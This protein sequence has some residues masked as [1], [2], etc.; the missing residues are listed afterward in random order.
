MVAPFGRLISSCLC[1]KAD[2]LPGRPTAA[3]PLA[4]PR[5]ISTLPPSDGC[6][7]TTTETLWSDAAAS[8][9]VG[10][11]KAKVHLKDCRFLK[12]VC[13]I[14]YLSLSLHTLWLIYAPGR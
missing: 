13:T 12:S 1:R 10:P 6:P 4:S 9:E 14:C 3:C 2:L 5:P 7:T 11:L 8:A